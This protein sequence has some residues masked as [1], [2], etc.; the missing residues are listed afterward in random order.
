MALDLRGICASL[1]LSTS[2]VGIL[3]GSSKSRL[4]T[5]LVGGMGDKMWGKFLRFE[6]LTGE[7]GRERNWGTELVWFNWRCGD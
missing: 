6:G 7:E 3:S 1:V 2:F 5:Y 4:C